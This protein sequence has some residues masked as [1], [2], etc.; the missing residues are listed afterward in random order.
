MQFPD[1]KTLGLVAMII[2]FL[3]SGGLFRFAFGNRRFISIRL[4]AYGDLLL[5]AG[6]LL[7]SFKPVIPDV[8]SLAG[9]N[10][11]ILLAFVFFISG[12]TSF[13]RILFPLQWL[14]WFLLALI[15]GALVY[16]TMFDMPALPAI[17]LIN[18][19]ILGESVYGALLFI[20]DGRKGLS[21]QKNSMASGFT[22]IALYALLRIVMAILEQK[23]GRLIDPDLLFAVYFIVLIFF[24][25]NSGFSLIWIAGA[26][27]EEDLDRRARLDPLT[28]ALNRRAFLD[29]LNRE[30][31]RSKRQSLTFSLIMGDIDHFKEINDRNGHLAGD[32]VLMAFKALVEQNLR[33]N[34]VLSRYGEEEFMILLPDTEKKNAVE[35]AERIRKIVEINNHPF[36]GQDIRFTVSFGVTSFDMDAQNKDELLEN[37]DIALYEAKA[38]GRNRVEF[39]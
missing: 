1:I 27:L 18:S 37:T 36:N 23:T 12:T 38:K 11:L 22:V 8:I 14:H 20:R 4:F 33:I 3:I 19:F 9:S 10:G 29:E 25:I 13:L 17:I 15:A 39:K 30:I 2:S 21:S 6:L 32:S 35:T 5:L 28:G 34:D 24:L 7:S 16:I 31:A 26:V